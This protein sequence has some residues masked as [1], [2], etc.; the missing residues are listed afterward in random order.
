MDD[1]T[2]IYKLFPKL[3]EY[4]FHPSGN[5]IVKYYNNLISQDNEKQKKIFINLIKLFNYFYNFND[6]VKFYKSYEINKKLNFIKEL[7][8]LF[9]EINYTENMNIQKKMSELYENAFDNTNIFIFNNIVT[10]INAYIQHYRF[11]NKNFEI[12]EKIDYL[13]TVY[14]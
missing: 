2:L 13:E 7:N 5:A 14:I 11:I 8:I 3:K 9:P 6:E 12:F 10:I 4:F 1:Y